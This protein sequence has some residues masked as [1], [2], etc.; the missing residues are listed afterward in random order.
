MANTVWASGANADIAAPSVEKIALGWADKEYP[1]NEWFNWLQNRTDTRLNVLE[2]SRIRMVD[3]MDPHSDT[4]S[5]YALN[6]QYTVPAY[7]VG[8][9]ELQ[10]YIDGVLCNKG[11]SYDEVGAA[12]NTSTK[13]K[14]LQAIDK[15]Y[16][17]LSRAP[18]QQ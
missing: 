11:E 12:G 2:D 8:T 14:W 1:P 13:I 7:V 16:D 15:T 5:T 17:I 6:S 10:V 18:V 9:G 4:R 3:K